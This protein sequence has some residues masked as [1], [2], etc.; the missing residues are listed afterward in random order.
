MKRFGNF[1]LYPAI[2]GFVVLS[3]A[4]GA[5]SASAANTVL[6]ESSSGFPY[7]TVGTGGTMKFEPISGTVITST[8][9]ELLTEVLNKTLLDIHILYLGFRFNGTS[10]SNTSNAEAVLIEMLGHIGLAD[11]G[12]H[13]AVLLLVPA[14]FEF[15][16]GPLVTV[17][18][19]GAYIGEITKPALLTAGQKEM[20]LKFEETKG[21]Q[22]YTEFLLPGGVLDKGEF[23]EWS[24]G[25]GAF[26]QVGQEGEM[27]L[28]ATGTGTFE[29]KDE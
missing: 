15:K 6:F 14:G 13:P 17:K 27:T 23:E 19:R 4:F 29:L 9:S 11:P 21:V 1:F 3:G 8:S 18:E 26:E 5:G 10:C 24:L 16:C 2:L 12:D 22:K 25:G 28:K 20:T 7:H